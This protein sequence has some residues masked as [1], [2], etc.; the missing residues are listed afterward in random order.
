MCKYDFAFIG[1]SYRD[2]KEK[3]EILETYDEFMLTK[4]DFLNY[5]YKAESTLLA[6][7][8][9]YKKNIHPHEVMREKDLAF[10]TEFEAKAVIEQ[11]FYK[12]KG[13]QDTIQTF[14]NTYLNWSSAVANVHRNNIVQIKYKKDKNT[15]RRLL[16]KSLIDLDNFYNI[17]YSSDNKIKLTYTIPLL[18]FRYGIIG[19]EASW[20]T[21][22][23]YRDVDFTNKKVNIV[24]EE[25]GELISELPVDDRF[26][27]YISR[28]YFEADYP[29]EDA[30]IMSSLR[31][32]DKAF[33]KFLPTG[34]YNKIKVFC[35]TLGI[36]RMS[37]TDLKKSRQLD[38]MIEVRIRNNCIYGNDIKNI[39][40]MLFA[41]EYSQT[42]LTNM[43]KL[44]ELATDERPL[45]EDFTTINAYKLDVMKETN[46]IENAEELIGFN[47]NKEYFNFNENS[48]ESLKSYSPQEKL[49]TED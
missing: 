23:R 48:A 13:T 31:K 3:E 18:F 29:T 12:S 47:Y 1:K 20:A 34:V 22:L 24:D 49:N 36:K 19:K 8:R 25:T 21:N 45:S 5:M 15:Q 17:L 28:A 26:L 6:L 11:N 41:R 33:V 37:P 7:W 16:R 4:L 39:A 10:F 14:V 44:Y 40:D 2:E 43:K 9:M 32:G 42:V 30:Y 35:T 46:V 27:S 38:L